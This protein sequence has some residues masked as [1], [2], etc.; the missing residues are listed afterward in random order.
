MSWFEDLHINLFG[1]KTG[2]QINAVGGALWAV[3]AL[4][5]I[6]VWWQGIGNWKRGLLV[7]LKSGWKRFNWDLHS[8]FG[9]WTMLLTL[10]WGVTGIFAA[11]PDPFRN[12]VEYLEPLQRIEYPAA[13]NGGQRGG[14]VPQSQDR[15]STE[16][17]SSQIAPNPSGRRGG[18][19]RRPQF[20]TRVGDQI[21]R[22]AYAL[23]FGNFAGTKLKIA[24]TILGLI[25][26]LL[27]LTGFLMWFNRKI[28]S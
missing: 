14:G 18:R 11:I 12:A 10:M 7:R 2:R 19:G 24:W 15:N 22:G 17:G 8:S 1:G 5:G 25:P 4:T 20:K 26:G 13:P 28:R 9:F 6:V 3:L 16:T 21:L 27:F 23:H